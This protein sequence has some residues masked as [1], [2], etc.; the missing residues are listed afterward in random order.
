MTPREPE[1][2]PQ[3]IH[4]PSC[5][6][7]SYGKKLRR[8]LGVC[9]LCGH[10]GRLSARER[11]ALLTD[12]DTFEEIPV[13]PVVHDPLGFVA[14]QPYP[15]RVEAASR[16]TGEDAAVVCGVAALAGHAVA[17]A[18]MDFRFLGGSLGVGAGERITA[19]AEHALAERL[20]TLL[21]T[22]SG[23]ARMQ[24]GA[25]SLLQMAKVSQAIA[26]LHEANLLTITLVTDPTYGGVAASY[27]TQSDVIVAEPGARLGIAGPRVIR[28]PLGADLPP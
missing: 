6:Q 25:L 11:I 8:N 21:V 4:C 15:Q 13:S 3:W 1:P 9:P 7:P 10:H 17:M 24:E 20:P 28:Q 12:P 2:A 14:S 18:V 22:A 27:A 16:T 19:I 23:G 26:R 5:R